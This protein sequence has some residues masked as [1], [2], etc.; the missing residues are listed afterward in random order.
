MPAA[1]ALHR[2]AFFHAMPDMPVLHTPG[3]DVAYYTR[4]LFVRNTVWL[5][6]EGDGIAGFIAF[7]PGW[8]DQLYIHPDHQG[9]GLGSRLLRV[10]QEENPVLRL[11]TFQRNAGA[12]QFYER[13][14]FLIEQETDGAGNEERQPDVLYRWTREN[15]GKVLRIP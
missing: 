1:A 11:W 5:A 13:H 8:V 15:G 14:G 10:A 12:R 7:R 6:C 2:L 9:R 3:E 4:V